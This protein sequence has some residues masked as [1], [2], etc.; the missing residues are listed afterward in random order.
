[1]ERIGRKKKIETISCGSIF[2]KRYWCSKTEHQ[3]RLPIVGNG[4]GYFGPVMPNDIGHNQHKKQI[5]TGDVSSADTNSS[6]QPPLPQ[7]ALRATEN[8]LRQHRYKK[9]NLQRAFGK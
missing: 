8:N 9:M 6:G 5:R 4:L 7:G 1:M 3:K 2:G